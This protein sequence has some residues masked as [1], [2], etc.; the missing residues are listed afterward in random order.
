[1]EP[2]W[3]FAILLAVGVAG[4]LLNIQTGV[5]ATVAE[6]ITGRLTASQIAAYASDAGFSGDNLVTAVAVALAE[7]S[8]NPNASGDNGTSYGLWQ[9]HYTV[10]PEVLSGDDPSVLFDPARNA[11][12]AMTVFQE[13]GWNAWSTYGTA[14]GHNNAYTKYLDDASQAVNA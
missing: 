6:A 13:Q 4:Y 3:V 10:H 9:I 12:A 7:S 2:T 5:V 14:P 8:G 1:M 11:A